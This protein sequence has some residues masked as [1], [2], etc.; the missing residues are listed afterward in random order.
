MPLEFKSVPFEPKI[1]NRYIVEFG[2]PFEIPNFV[3]CEAS[4]PSINK[5]QC[6]IVWEDMVFG[7]YDPITPSTGQ[8]VING[9]KK[10][11]QLDDQSI[12]IIIKILGP[13]GDTVE[14]WEVV[15]DIK[16]IDFGRLEYKSADPL[17]IRITIAVRY[18]KLIF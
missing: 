13:V 5:T 18:A 17:I 12:S 1:E 6:G 10:L 9:I 4:R 7:M 8:V 2:A 16:S 15:G 14:Q 11:M 3:I